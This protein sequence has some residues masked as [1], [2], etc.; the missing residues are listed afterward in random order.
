MWFSRTALAFISLLMIGFLLFAC[1]AYRPKQVPKSPPPEVE[2]RYLN[3]IWQH[4]TAFYGPDQKNIYMTEA[5]VTDSVLSGVVNSY[6]G[7]KP[8]K[9]KGQRID[10]HVSSKVPQ[11]PD[12]PST[13]SIP[14]KDISYIEVYDYD[15][16]RV[17]MGVAITVLTTALIAGTIVLIITAIALANKGS[18]PFIYT[19]DGEDYNFTGE[20]YSGAI[21]PGLERDDFLPL[22]GFQPID[23]AYQIKMANQVREIQHTNLAELLVADHPAGTQLLVDRYGALHTYRNLRQ[24]RSAKSADQADI[25]PLLARQD[26]LKFLGEYSE[27]AKQ[28]KDTVYLSFDRPSAARAGKLVVRAKT[29]FWLDHTLNKFFEHFGERYQQWFARQKEASGGSHGTWPME[30]NIPL[31]VYL[32]QD[33]KWQF[34]DY[35]DVT[36][37]M[38]EEDMILPLD[39][40]KVDSPTVELKLECGFHFWEID[41]VGM[42]FSPAEQVYPQR[43]PISGALDQSGRDVASLMATADSEYYS[44]PEIGNQA[45]LK[46]PA[47]PKRADYQRSVFLHSSGYYEVLR[48]PTGKPDVAFLS[49]FRQPG[50]LAEY[51]RE[52]FEDLHK[53]FAKAE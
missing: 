22:P 6:P 4:G 28:T 53:Q 30:Q 29:S 9:N 38:A 10:I 19:Y 3:L 14:L 32:K 17:V 13:L 45:I 49:K 44:M 42:D 43:V 20:I 21:N 31:S 18:C 51:S 34:V 37:P 33:G 50:R 39:L 2:G 23:S 52:L 46:F 47:P 12:L 24:P 41:R 25:L 26:S 7:N 8:Y 27:S 16:S 40:S 5:S 35:F 11:P 15:V 36:G 1:S 48:T